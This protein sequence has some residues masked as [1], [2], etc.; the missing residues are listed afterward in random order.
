MTEQE[1]IQ[2]LRRGDVA[3]LEVL[4]RRYQLKAVH[5]AFLVT[6]DKGT[7]EEVVQNA[8]L[9]VAERIDQ[10]DVT[11]PFAPGLCVLWSMVP[12]R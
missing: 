11:R 1:A 4:V 8:F 6:Q 9:R 2:A 5:A 12:S 3:G 10:F 7:A